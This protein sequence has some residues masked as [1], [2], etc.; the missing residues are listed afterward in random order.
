MLLRI[1]HFSI[2]QLLYLL[3]SHFFPAVEVAHIGYQLIYLIYPTL[4]PKVM[5]TLAAITVLLNKSIGAW[6]TDQEEHDPPVHLFEEEP[7]QS[8]CKD[9]PK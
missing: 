9:V 8:T 2:E 6:S 1:F 3:L 5:K 7:T 4:H